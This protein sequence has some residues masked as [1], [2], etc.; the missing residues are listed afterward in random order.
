VQL[1]NDEIVPAYVV[2]PFTV[3]VNVLPA[4]AVLGK[5]EQ[6]GRFVRLRP[7][8]GTTILTFVAVGVLGSM[9]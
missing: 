9:A 7:E 2:A 4:G 5:F 8:A 6:P 1:V 3:S